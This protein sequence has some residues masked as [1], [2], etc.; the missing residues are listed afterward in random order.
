MS[1]ED[2][3]EKKAHHGRDDLTGEHKLGDSGQLILFAI[4]IVVWIA[5]SFILHYTDFPAQYIPYY[6]RIGLA[7]VVLV[8]GAYIAM[9]SH[10]ILFKEKR[11]VPAVIRKGI[12]GT[13]RHPLYLGAILFYLG[14]LIVTC[15]LIATMIWLIIIGFYHFIARY[16]ERLL[17]EK[18]GEDY[19]RYMEKVPMWLPRTD[20]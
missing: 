11:E 9:A 1:K 20:K 5:D 16:E 14:L 8:L 13:V 15:S 18:F 7:A 10:N 4:F 19:I 3:L 17:L 12:F 6:I 2:K